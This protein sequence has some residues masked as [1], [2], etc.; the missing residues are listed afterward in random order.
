MRSVVAV[1]VLAEGNSEAVNTA[2]DEIFLA[3][4]LDR[5]KKITRSLF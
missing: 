3:K 2:I 5:T 1:C 4:S